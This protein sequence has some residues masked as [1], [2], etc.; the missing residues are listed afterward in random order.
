M[1]NSSLN[2]SS[3]SLRH[4]LALANSQSQGQHPP[5]MS[6]SVA[7]SSGTTAGSTS[8]L[9]STSSTPFSSSTSLALPLLSSLDMLRASSS[10]T[11]DPAVLST[12]ASSAGPTSPLTGAASLT[13]PAAV[14][15]A[16]LALAAAT[17]TDQ[18]LVHRAAGALNAI[19]LSPD[20]ECAVVAGREVLKVLKVVDDQIKE[21]LNLRTGSR[22]NLNLSSNDVKWSNSYAKN[23]V[24]TAA[25]NGAI[26][27][28]DIQKPGQK[29]DRVIN[30]HQRA[31]NRLAFHPSEPVILLSAS[32]DSSLKLWDLRT[33]GP[34]R[35]TFECKAEAARDVQFNP[36]PGAAHEF[37]AAFENGTVQVWD[38]RHT[39]QYER[40]FAAHN[41]LVLAVDYH[42]SGRWLATGGRD[43]LIKV[44]DLKRSPDG[45]A[46][47]G[48]GGS[49]RPST[50]TSMRPTHQIQTI[51]SV[52]RLAWRPSAAHMHLTS[53]A[54]LTDYRVHVWDLAR[55]HVPCAWFEDHVNVA[56]GFVWAD[57]QV[58]WSCGKDK[59]VIKR[60]FEGASYSPATHLPRAAVTWGP[61]G[62]LVAS[63]DRPGGPRVGQAW[64]GKGS[65]GVEG[66][67]PVK[68]VES[69]RNS[70]MPPGLFSRRSQRRV[71]PEKSASLPPATASSSSAH[72]APGSSLSGNANYPS[73]SNAYSS[74]NPSTATN[75]STIHDPTDIHLTPFQANQ[76]TLHLTPA[77][78]V[79]RGEFSDDVSALLYQAQHYKLKSGTPA[80]FARACAHNAR[81]A[82]AMGRFDQWR[83]WQLAGV[84]LVPLVARKATSAPS[85]LHTHVPLVASPSPQPP[86]VPVHV[87]P[88]VT[89]DSLMV[90]GS[91][92]STM[93]T[94]SSSSTVIGLGVRRGIP[95][96]PPLDPTMSGPPAS[97]SRPPTRAASTQPPATSVAFSAPSAA[98][99]S[100]KHA[101]ASTS[102]DPISLN[103]LL[104]TGAAEEMVAQVL[105][106]HADAG[107][108]HVCAT[109]TILLLDRGG[110]DDEDDDDE[111]GEEEPGLAGVARARAAQ[112]G[113][114][115]QQDEIMASWP[116]WLVKEQVEEW[117]V[118][119]I[120]LLHRF[121]LYPTAASILD[122]CPL[123]SVRARLQE[124]T[125]IFTSCNMCFKPMVHAG[126]YARAYWVCERCQKLVNPCSLCHRV[127]KGQYV[128]CQGCGH[129]GHVQCL[130]A[131]FMQ[132]NKECPTGCGHEC[133]GTMVG[134]GAG[135]GGGGRH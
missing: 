13:D 24:A 85:P 104:G 21:T 79:P 47:A 115:K 48:G 107:D 105:A 44:W 28:W 75:S 117:F 119:Y 32:Q 91:A 22:L 124:S 83:T 81:V 19:S 23:T 123:P 60:R 39:A 111:D 122:R 54:L 55:P 49:G 4:Q 106:H 110:D 27:I 118:D 69:F 71:P 57:D 127:V 133:R 89:T 16:S 31:V 70:V 132:G 11:P 97:L 99:F 108:V 92:Q 15:G 96:P 130:Y 98:T 51:A 63:L 8:V 129:G 1:Y 100:G 58:L 114:R 20:R 116:A 43:K 77:V 66:Q 113:Y 7:A 131:W 125:T 52:G 84:A 68:D 73:S 33:K 67:G 102:G 101:P 9:H 76:L 12:A 64:V 65:E 62:D 6:S 82:A 37:V 30:E 74:S 112:Q 135:G 134:A 94:S 26:V 80:R 38:L 35:H 95:T 90:V 121:K 25:T 34:A 109:L 128:W 17:S 46:A 72:F 93:S 103:E 61:S 78:P 59:R 14:T 126:H 50:A 87:A 36:S 45:H 42:A 41:G 10:P 56:T 18:S 120:D 40:R 88:A 5:H 29:L 53:S 2:A 86:Q 3:S